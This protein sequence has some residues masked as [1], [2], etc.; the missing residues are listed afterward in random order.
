MIIDSIQNKHIKLIKKLTIPKYQKKFQ[1]YIIEGRNLVQEALHCQKPLEILATSS[2]VDQMSEVSTKFTII[3]SQVAKYLSSTVATEGIFAIM[4]IKNELPQKGNWLIFDELQDPGNAGT[5]LRTADFFDYQGVF[6][7]SR[8]VSPYSPKLLRAAQ[9][10]NFHL[11]V[12]EGE[13]FSFLE[14]IKKWGENILGTTLHTEAQEVNDLN[15]E[16][17]FA[18]ILG[19]EGHGLRKEVDEYVDNN[20]IIPA[21]G[22]AESLNVS[23]AAGILMYALNIKN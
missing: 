13:I 4:E 11:Q 12:V 16:E 17:S 1:Q 5:I 15:I 20:I 9:G 8:S 2:Y 14:Q 22:K 3:S 18:L 21:K 7:S 19:N 6:F 23:I 10:S